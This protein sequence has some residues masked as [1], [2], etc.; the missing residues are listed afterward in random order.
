MSNRET[1]QAYE[2]HVEAYVAGTSAEVSGPPRQWMDRA[3]AG[4]A[5][6]ARILE[7]GSAFGRDAAYLQGRG[8]QVE[9][10]DACAGFLALLR[11]KGFA[12]RALNILTDTV[13]GP[14]DLILA[15]AVL[16]HLSRAEFSQVLARLAAS[17]APGGRFAFSLKRGDGEG[18]SSH[19]LGAPRYFCYWQPEQLPPLLAVAGFSTWDLQGAALARTHADWLY[20]IAVR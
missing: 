10:S 16:L 3:V 12:A 18:W 15:N 8:Y 11:A 19:K 1:L 9:C 13:G 14:Y 4:L 7:L 17:L 5:P 6:S 20:G 2:E